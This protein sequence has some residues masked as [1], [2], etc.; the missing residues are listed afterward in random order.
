MAVLSRR[1]ATLGLLVTISYVNAA[2]SGPVEKVIHKFS[3]S[4]DGM[5]PMG[6]LVADKNGN[7]YG[8]TFRGGGGGSLGAGVV[9]EL[10]P[11]AVQGGDWTETILYS[12]AGGSDGGARRNAGLRQPRQSLRGL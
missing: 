3:G 6:A 10:S 11:P 4:P 7:L 9:F 8:T 1:I 5:T 2:A 12:F